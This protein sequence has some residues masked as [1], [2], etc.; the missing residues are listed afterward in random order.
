MA[1]N[2]LGVISL[3]EIGNHQ[4][5]DI[6]AQMA[7]H[8]GHAARWSNIDQ[9]SNLITMKSFCLRGSYIYYQEDAPCHSGKFRADPA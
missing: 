9:M 4:A 7:V 6:I 8:Q 2:R 5:S 1:R 3:A